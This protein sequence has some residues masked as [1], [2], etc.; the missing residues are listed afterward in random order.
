M[1]PP[2]LTH[3]SE[4]CV[5]TVK[6]TP[7]ASR[8][9]FVASAGEP[10]L[11]ARL[12]APPVDGKANAALLA[13][14]ARTFALPPRAVTLLTGETARHKRLLLHGVTPEAVTSAL[15]PQPGNL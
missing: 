1:T 12:Q 4:G 5:L 2:W 10:W 3:T 6:A 9:E 15:A 7:R 13:L 11:R 14:A 8:S